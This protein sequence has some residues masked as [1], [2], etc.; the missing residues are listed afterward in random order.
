[1]SGRVEIGVKK[2]MK[3]IIKT[4]SDWEV[5]DQRKKELMEAVARI[6]SSA[7]IQYIKFKD[8]FW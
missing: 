3:I 5:T 6:L 2:T 4:I 1:M 8:S 7:K